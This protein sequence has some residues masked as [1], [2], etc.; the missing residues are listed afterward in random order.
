MK[1]EIVQDRNEV[2]QSEY[3][4]ENGKINRIRHV[5]IKVLARLVI[6]LP[7]LATSLQPKAESLSENRKDYPSQTS[8]IT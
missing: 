3:D 6:F 1:V 4:N 5:E 2:I 7:A 8:Q